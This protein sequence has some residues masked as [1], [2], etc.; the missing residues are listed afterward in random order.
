MA[1]KFIETRNVAL[2]DL[3]RYPGNARRG[4]VEEIRKS[5]RRH[6]QYR[7]IVVRDTGDSLVILAG[8]HTYQALDA[9]DAGTARCEIITCTDDE[10][11][12]IN[13]AD[14]RT[15]ELGDYDGDALVELLSYLD[16]DYDGTG[17]TEE[18]VDLLVN[19]P[20]PALDGDPDDDTDAPISRGELLELAGVTIGEPRHQ[21]ERG[22]V[23]ALGEHRL[24]IADIFKDWALW[25]PFLRDDVTFLPYPTPLVPH[26]PNAGRLVLVQPELYLAGHLLD[27]WQNI[28]G[29]EPAVLEAVAA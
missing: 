24:I 14:N 3:T 11:R 29:Q 16:G 18:A 4:N 20:E 27:K 10:A 12:R 7:A 2:S 22:Q 17:W 6:G 8:N 23:W 9:E 21:V 1:A 25:V 5:I 13:L 19:I 28:T 26:A 15:A